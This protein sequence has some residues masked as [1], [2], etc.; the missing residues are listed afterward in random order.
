MSDFRSK[1]SATS[2]QASFDQM[3]KQFGVVTVMNAKV[4]LKPLYGSESGCI[5]NNKY[6]DDRAGGAQYKA[7]DILKALLDEA[8]ANTAAN[9]T[10]VEI[11]T[12]KIANINMEGP[13]KTITGGQYVNPL[14]KFGKTATIE[15]QD[16]LGRADVIEALGGGVLEQFAPDE[17]GVIEN[18]Q[19]VLH[20]G[21]DFAGAKTIL[22]ESF[23]IDRQ[24]GAQVKVYI[25]L[26]EMLPDS[27]M[28]LTQ[29]AEG[30]ATVFDLNGSLSAVDIMIGDKSDFNTHAV[31]KGIFYSVLPQ[32]VDYEASFYSVDFAKA[33]GSAVSDDTIA[34][35]NMQYAQKVKAGDPFTMPV[36]EDLTFD[37]ASLDSVM[38]DTEIKVKLASEA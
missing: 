25:I 29:D 8:A 9:P 17:N 36:R 21:Q 6:L 16:A 26:Y 20:M 35:L 1:S 5:I 31:S 3:I 2:V 38:A 19:Y 23:F 22:G 4:F 27:I 11:D 7:H 32:E 30:D 28:N 18:N 37:P 10:Y 12:L 14:I 33:D 15:M 34:L 13:T 24:T